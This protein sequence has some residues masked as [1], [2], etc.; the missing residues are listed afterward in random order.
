MTMPYDLQVRAW[1]ALADA[2]ASMNGDSDASQDWL[3]RAHHTLLLMTDHMQPDELVQDG[4]LT[5]PASRIACL[6]GWDVFDCG[7][8]M[9][10]Q[11][12]DDTDDGPTR[13]DND[14]AAVA[15][16]K[17]RADSNEPGTKLHAVALTLHAFT[18]PE[19]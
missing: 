12:N 7:D 13:F 8:E 3:D 17:A 14:E 11:G 18:I 16:V 19:N 6:D 9:R 4:Q 2:V 5:V 10:I 1:F 15:Y